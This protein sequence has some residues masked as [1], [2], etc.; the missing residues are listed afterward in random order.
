[1]IN[2]ENAIQVLEINELVNKEWVCVQ[3][4][5]FWLLHSSWILTVWIQ[6]DTSKTE[7]VISRSIVLEST[8]FA[9]QWKCL[10]LTTSVACFWVT[11]SLFSEV[12][13]P[14]FLLIDWAPVLM[15]Q[16]TVQLYSVMHVHFEICF[17]DYLYCQSL[18]ESSTY[19]NN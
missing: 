16:C 11:I 17:F 7:V 10:F 3:E 18:N 19:F 15:V 2:Y 12:L 4:I 13:F 5:Y 9:W 6:I 1:M 8:L 14:C